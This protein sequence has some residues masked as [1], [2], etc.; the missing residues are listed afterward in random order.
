MSGGHFDYVQHRM[1]DA[2]EKLERVIRTADD[3]QSY[4][5]ETIQEFVEGY[6]YLVYAAAFLHRID[7]L[8]SLDDSEESFHKLL[9][10]DVDKIT[11]KQIATGL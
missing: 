4:N 7:R 8:I 6:Q 2:A 1:N 3:E 11:D 10:E 5:I 9:A